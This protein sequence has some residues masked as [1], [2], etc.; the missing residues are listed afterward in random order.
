MESCEIPFRLRRFQCVDFT[1]L[2][3]AEGIKVTKKLLRALMA[4]KS[5]SVIIE[6]KNIGDTLKIGEELIKR[7]LD[8]G[9]HV[10]YQH[11]VKGD[12]KK[13]AIGHGHSLAWKD[14]QDF[15]QDRLRLPW[16]EF[17]HV[18][19]AGTTDIL[20]LSKMLDS[21]AMAFLV[22]TTEDEQA[23]SDL[24]IQLNV[25]HEVGL[26]QGRLGFTRAIILLEEGCVEFSDIQSLELL[27][28]PKGSIK[29]TFEDIRQVLEREGIIAS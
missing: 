10:D 20:R 9:N 8:A 14:L 16:D 24:R 3:D 21:A 26:F 25:A 18:P 28:F 12:R 19:V 22:V 7:V 11:V 13:I 17:N 4:D 1:N 15:I 2:G 23:D 5:M 27:K 6:E 29:A